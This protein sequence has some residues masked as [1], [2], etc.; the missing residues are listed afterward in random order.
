MGKYDEYKK[1]LY[2]SS[3]GK[4]QLDKNQ[5]T[6]N[7]YR[8]RL[9]A[10]GVDPDE[11][12]DKRNWLEKTLNL[13]QDQNVLFD[14]FELLNRPQQALFTG[15]K[16]AQE[17]GDFW[18]GAK[19]GL[20]GNKETQFK[21]ILMNTGYFDDEK[22]KLDLVD[23]LGFGGDVFL[24]P[25]DLVPVAGL[26][27]AS[28][29]LNEGGNLRDAY[30]ATDSMTDLFF[31]GAGKAVKGTAKG[32]DNLIEKSLAKLDET[33]GVLNNA[34]DV[35][36]LKYLQEGA[37]SGANLVPQ[38]I[39]GLQDITGA[40]GRLQLYKNA[41]NKIYNAFNVSDAAKEAIRTKRSLDASAD[42]S[43]EISKI[44]IKEITDKAN[45]FAETT[46]SK[47][48]NANELLN[49]S[50][51][52]INSTV[53]RTMDED[54]LINL[55]K[56]GDM[57]AYPEAIEHL[58]NALKRDVSDDVIQQ[59]QQKYGKKA[60]D[61]TVDK[62]N[63]LKL[64]KGW[65]EIQ[66]SNADEITSELA[67][68]QKRLK[69]LNSMTE[70][71]IQKLD[72][73]EALRLEDEAL[74]LEQDVRRLS[75]Q[76]EAY[77]VRFNRRYT[78]EQ[79]QTIRKYAQLYGNNVDGYRDFVDDIFGTAWKRQDSDIMS[80]VRDYDDFGENIFD[81][82]ANPYSVPLSKNQALVMNPEEM[83]SGRSTNRDII[84]PMKDGEVGTNAETVFYTD[85]PYMATGY[86]GR[87]LA[88][89]DNLGETGG[90]TYRGLLS[91]TP[92]ENI[93]NIGPNGK[94]SDNVDDFIDTIDPSYDWGSVP[95]K[96]NDT[97]NT[98]AKMT[99]KDKDELT[100]I[101]NNSTDKRDFLNKLKENEDLVN[102]LKSKYKIDIGSI[103]RP[104]MKDTAELLEKTSKNI[105]SD[106]LYDIINK[107]KNDDLSF[108][109]ALDILFRTDS[110]STDD[111][112]ENIYK[113]QATGRNTDTYNTIN[114][115]GINDSIV[116]SKM[117]DD[118]VT[119]NPGTSDIEQR[120]FKAL[121]NRTPALETPNVFDVKEN[122]KR[123]RKGGTDVFNDIMD[124]T[125]NTN[126]GKKYNYLTNDNYVAANILT[127]EGKKIVDE[128]SDFTGKRL[129]KGNSNL[130]N[131]RKYVGAPE[132]TN[133]F[134]REFVDK[135]D[136]KDLKDYP[137]LKAFKHNKDAKF[138]E[139]DYIK[140]LT[141]S[142]VDEKGL[143]NVA[144]ATQL[145]NQTLLDK[146]FKDFDEMT[147]VQKE[148]E[149]AYKTRGKVSKE[150][151]K[152]Y[153]EL[154]DNSA[155]K[156]LTKFDSG[157]PDNFT[158]KTPQE[159]EEILQ[160]YIKTNN[161]FGN[162][163][164]SKGL[165]D[166]LK[167]ITKNGNDVAINNDVLRVIGAV[168]DTKNVS[169]LNTIYN[170]Y[171]NHFRV[172]KT[173]SP[174]NFLNNMFGNSS[175]MILGGV[176]MADQARL[177]PQVVDIMT[178]G[179]KYYLQKLSGV[180]LSAKASKTADMWADF[181][182]MGFG[183]ASL[184]LA[185]LPKE[186]R[187]IIQKNKKLKGAKDYITKGLPSMF[188]YLNQKGDVAARLT[189]MLKA[190]ESPSFLKKL[191]A[192][193]AYEAISKI[194]F[195]PEMLT[196]TEKSIKQLIPFYTYAKNNLVY[197]VT[198]LQRNGKKYN[199]LMKTMKS[200]RKAATNGNEDD[201]ADYIK[202]NLYIPLPGLDKNGNYS[203][204]RAQLPFGD[205]L[206]TI[207]NPLQRLANM[208]SP[209]VKGI[210]EQSTGIDAFTGRPIE[211]F[212]GQ[213]SNNINLFG[214]QPSKRL[215]KAISDFSGMDVFLKNA[216]RLMSDDPLNMVRMRN[217]VDTDKLNRS[218]EQIDDLKNLMKQYEQKGYE[219][220]TM[221][222]LKKANKNGTVAGLDALFAKYGIK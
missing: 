157:I 9:A 152:R 81:N 214:W 199:Q 154:F 48:G 166:L 117:G 95:F 173:A 39:D 72:P 33:K 67:T 143:T 144:G 151:S 12:T 213:K 77:T 135:I 26:G 40:T 20:T 209:I 197:Q 29:I 124:D 31:K 16:N 97:Y 170:K 168:S 198:N 179:E 169:A 180:S 42:T 18:E 21:D 137:A 134:F 193:D 83:Y 47:Y 6:I 82:A 181:R 185:E 1:I 34:G 204:I 105:D 102:H 212:P 13:K 186:V 218:Y 156:P 92:E 52:M 126:L 35:V 3:S 84:K 62:G 121:A 57:P 138:M 187:D 128:L 188:G 30:K 58:Q 98:Y 140:A 28:K 221:S 208:S 163:A 46:G 159:L 60:F 74:E 118:T 75:Q 178:N 54:K 167:K 2:G 4:T 216:T 24:D 10:G 112:A 183:N 94:I 51:M 8:A 100:K 93:L 125:I 165:T 191:G 55:A 160:K 196:S 15:W 32:A 89:A 44:K 113:N 127:P 148:M 96:D 43:R 211:S 203:V 19:E 114:F 88:T 73:Y 109:E 139:T 153:K 76:K 149:N 50:R 53:N 201:M 136:D 41:K 25:A 38:A 49:N 190:Y 99:K 37:K 195:D 106:N 108:D 70:K 120:K 63:K 184:D 217:N 131:T 14:I 45:K 161:Q 142:Y 101:F 205:I 107:A 110:R 162:T 182:K 11:A 103:D 200:L 210:Y 59:I 189:V 115:S 79:E 61:I 155:I 150:T 202:N 207:N 215:E 194:M 104:A 172:W 130:L 111:I 133:N 123:I 222:E 87:T 7:S 164:N 141:N 64:G 65:N 86:G 23:V 147:K 122:A 80:I 5:S 27:K 219:F 116:G 177:A 71:Q 90:V 68:K 171:L 66:L 158:K 132:E 22:G 175:N 69:K 56:K 78:P 176:S 85:N 192:K 91:K 174:T 220:S 129:G 119:I 36:K 146:S 206:E 17:G 145:V